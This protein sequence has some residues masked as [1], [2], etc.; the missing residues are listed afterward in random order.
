[1]THSRHYLGSH[2]TVPYREETPAGWSE[3]VA[4]GWNLESVAGGLRL[5]GDCPTCRH[6]SETRVEDA[7]LA[8]PGRTTADPM[9][10]I[11]VLIICRCGAEHEGRPAG[12]L[13]CGRAAYLEVAP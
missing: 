7:T 10:P 11:P 13:G 5:S 1:M 9:D 3:A 6:P 4:E 12:K 2:M 8:V